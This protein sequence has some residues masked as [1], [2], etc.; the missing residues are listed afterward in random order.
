MVT[1]TAKVT[2]KPTTG[3]VTDTITVKWGDKELISKEFYIAP[4]ITFA[5]HEG[6]LLYVDEKTII[7]II[8]SVKGDTSTN[9]VTV[10]NFKVVDNLGST[11]LSEESLVIHP[12]GQTVVSIEYTPV[13]SQ[14]DTGVQFTISYELGG[15]NFSYT[16][17]TI[18]VYS[19]TGTYSLTAEE[20]QVVYDTDS[21]IVLS[22]D[23]T[24]IPTG[25]T[26]TFTST[27]GLNA[28]DTLK[29]N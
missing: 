8:P 13:S 3:H 16:V 10:T 6:T 9:N 17:S 20:G 18:P 1:K 25:E 19:T 26:I 12:S 4:I 2:Y 24:K 14:V 21:T 11:V 15:Y 5:P 22:S 29:E 28:T 7:H 27:E 23:D